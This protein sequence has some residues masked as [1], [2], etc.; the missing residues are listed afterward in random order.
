[1]VKQ[2]GKNAI[3]S[4]R[5]ASL[6]LLGKNVSAHELMITTISDVVKQLI[7]AYEQGKDIDLNK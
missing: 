7:D 2:K 4:S 3:I 6:N 5:N 1:M